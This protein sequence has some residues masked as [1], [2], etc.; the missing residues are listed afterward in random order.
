MAILTCLPYEVTLKHG[1][2]H[3]ESLG[4]VEARERTCIAFQL[5]ALLAKDKHFSK[6]PRHLELVER[7]EP[8]GSFRA[9]G[10]F[11]RRFVISAFPLMMT[12][13]IYSWPFHAVSRLQISDPKVNDAPQSTTFRVHPYQGTDLSFPASLYF[14]RKGNA[15]IWHIATYK[16]SWRL[17]YAGDLATLDIVILHDIRNV[18]LTI[19]QLF[20]QR[21]HLVE[22][23]MK[24]AVISL[25]VIVLT[26]A[27]ALSQGEFLHKWWWVTSDLRADNQPWN[28]GGIKRPEQ[29]GIRQLTSIRYFHHSSP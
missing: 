21:C 13:R 16:M 25:T 9:N 5:Y 19:S 27:G 14:T 23:K 7:F 20:V 4:I 3:N 17:L 11:S 2:M 8:A 26:H 18:E 1:I 29:T 15:S 12:S 28:N 10:S 22:A 6:L 24:L